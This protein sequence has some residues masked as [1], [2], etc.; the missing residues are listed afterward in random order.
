[1]CVLVC[2][3]SAIQ[4]ADADPDEEGSDDASVPEDRRTALTVGSLRE[5]CAVGVGRDQSRSGPMWVP[6]RVQLGD[7]LAKSSAGLFL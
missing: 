7:G 3:D 6:P 5:R 2:T 4:N 1:M